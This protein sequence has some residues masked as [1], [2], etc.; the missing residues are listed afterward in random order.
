MKVLITGGAGF[1]GSYIAKELLRRNYDVVILDIVPP[2][3]HHDRLTYISGDVLDTE[4]VRNILI[5]YEIDAI[6]HLVGLPVVSQCKKNP[7]LS[8]KLNALSVQSIMEAMRL[9]LCE[10][11]I[12]AS[13][14][15]VYGIPNKNPVKETD[16]LV[17]NTLY[18][19]HKLIGELAIRAYAHEYGIKGV[20]LRLFNVFGSDPSIGKDVI[21]IFLRKV[22]NREKLTIYD[23][24]KY[25]DFIHV[26]DV[27]RVFETCLRKMDLLF[28]NTE[29]KITVFNVGTGSYLKI[30]EIVDIIRDVIDTPINTEIIRTNDDGT[31]YFAD[32]TKMMRELNIKPKDARTAVTEFIRETLKRYLS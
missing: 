25:R 10:R 6:I 14:A 15:A 16:S 8:F 12:F 7:D 11:V 18:G 24:N 26:D 23:P 32:I 20:I 4:F 31:G 1:I 5:E 27:A 28:E 21:S 22:I 19:Y 29:N 17:P 2:H 3:F 13:S 30:I 9:S